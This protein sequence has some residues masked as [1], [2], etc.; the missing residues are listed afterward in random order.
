[1]ALPEDNDRTAAGKSMAL[2]DDQ[3]EQIAK[4]NVG[5]AVVYQNSWEEA[6]QCKI[7]QYDYDIIKRYTKHYEMPPVSQRVVRAEIINFLLYKL[8][9]NTI[10]IQQVTKCVERDSMPSSL[11]ISLLELLQE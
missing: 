10:D 9:N 1:M 11:R 2:T 8:T 3:I 4:Q 7:H 5:E 6:V